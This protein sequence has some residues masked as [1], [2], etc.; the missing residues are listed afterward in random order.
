MLR[1]MSV[2]AHFTAGILLKWGAALL[3]P[4]GRAQGLW[5]GATSAAS[6]VKSWVTLR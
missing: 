6:V 1:S 3:R 4:Y 5:F 2:D